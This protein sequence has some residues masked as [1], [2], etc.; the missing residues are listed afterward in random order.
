VKQAD[1]NASADACTQIADVPVQGLASEEDMK[2][3][4]VLP[5]LRALG[6]GDADFNY[7][8]WTGRGY[9]EVVVERFPVGTVVET[10]S[11]RT[12]LTDAG[13]AQLESY[14]F[15]QHTCDRAATVAMLT[16]GELFRLLGD[17]RLVTRRRWISLILN[18]TVPGVGGREQPH[19]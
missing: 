11:P 10:K 6:Y 19:R 2:I 7:E 17:I 3:K 8:G 9:V 4:I 18:A 15:H 5:L 12:R 16:N 14:V 13:I 1:V